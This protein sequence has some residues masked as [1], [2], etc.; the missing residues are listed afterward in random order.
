MPADK[1]VRTVFVGDAASLLRTHSQIE[2]SSAKTANALRGNGAGMDAAMQRS[3][4]ASTDLAKA[5]QLSGIGL[6]VALAAAAKTGAD[7]E[8]QVSLINA[9]LR[10]TSEGLQQLRQ[11]ALDMSRGT[12]FSATQAAQAITELGKAGVSTAAIHGGALKGALDLAAAGELS[13]AEAAETAASAMT[14][15]GLD[16]ASVPHIADLLAAG[17]GKA[18][19]SVHDLG[20]ALNQV[21]LVAHGTGLSIE[22]TTAG[23][24]AMASAGM[25]GSDAG[26]SFKSMLQRL[27]PTTTEAAAEMEQLGIHAY[28]AQGNFVGLEALAGN[29]Q[30]AMSG[31]TNEQRAAA[32]QII[33]GSDAVRAANVLYAQG[34]SGIAHWAKET[35]DAAYAAET[36]RLAQDNLIGDL[37]KLKQALSSAA[38]SGSGGINDTLRLLAQTAT[39]VVGA[40][41][42]IPGPVI[43]VAAALGL[44]AAVGP[45]VQS[46]GAQVSGGLGGI[47]RSITETIG[48][49]VRYQRSLESMSSGFVGVGNQSMSGAAKFAAAGSVVKSAASG[50]K[51]A[52]SGL[53]SALGGPWGLA[54]GAATVALGVY[55]QKQ[56]ESRARVQELTDII[57]SQG[58]VLGESSRQWAAKGL[59]DK[60]GLDAADRLGISLADVTDAALGNQEAMARVNA[61]LDK[62]R[63]QME[64]VSVGAGGSAQLTD[65]A[66]AASSLGKA[67]GGMSGQVSD[68]TRKQDQM[69][70]TTEQTAAAAS[71]AAGATK[72]L[73]SEQKKLAEDA[74]NAEDALKGALDA[75]TQLASGGRDLGAAQR[76][77]RQS[78]REMTDSLRAY[79]EATA[80]GDS[81]KL[82]EA[83]DKLG[84]AMSSTAQDALTEASAIIKNHGSVTDAA[85]A[86][87]LARAKVMDTAQAM[88]GSSA[89]ADALT[90]SIMGTKA[91]FVALAQAAAEADKQSVSIGV[92]VTGADVANRQVV[93]VHKALAGI[94]GL[95][96]AQLAVSGAATSKVDA[97]AL[98]ASIL[99]IPESKRTQVLSAFDKGGV[100]AAYAALNAIDGKVA[101]TYIRTVREVTTINRELQR[102]AG[103]GA[104]PQLESA[105]GNIFHF[106]GNG[107]FESHHAQIAPAGA[108][109]IW[110]EP[111]TGGEAYIPLATSKR[112]RSEELL[113]EVADIFGKQLIP[114]ANGR[115]LRFSS[116]SQSG[117]VQRYGDGG[118][119][120]SVRSGVSAN[121]APGV[122]GMTFA[123]VINA[124]GYDMADV[125]DRSMS[126]V[127]HEARAM[128]ISIPG[129]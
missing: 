112:R 114:A 16:G 125:I 2:A 7:F 78:I 36:A 58:Q 24:A 128:A 68:A 93:D 85:R 91:E 64:V 33:F 94:P 84:A 35:N 98:R 71:G 69:A 106:F 100:N 40:L 50:M 21:G 61:E 48:E 12:A 46:M 18:Q 28:D 32:M 11:D 96:T 57:S 52:A 101:T 76:A 124:T 25:I 5:A 77:T 3:A 122:G 89:K 15:F 82:A 59:Q 73:A 6:G 70:R 29:L 41:D 118:L 81:A 1:I 20:M 105:N 17:A 49:Q 95:T 111:E 107:G 43:Q 117:G 113:A 53:M 121:Q 108:M 127:R 14:Q 42:D 31:L 83:T 88:T 13:V 55:A 62:Y 120:H 75:M 38:I 10:P 54:L 45:R 97:D 79:K 34:A 8:R 104:A 44:M 23:L 4:K 123:P 39:T 90:S 63:G 103:R 66:K 109:R 80:G 116:L 92:K 99:A 119:S 27:V 67:I 30:S 56:A 115:L 19:G 74:K 26:T 86:Y 60:G 22:E 129:A 72:L 9:N 110:A 51:S 37:N 126:R 65:E 47:R 102:S 87:D